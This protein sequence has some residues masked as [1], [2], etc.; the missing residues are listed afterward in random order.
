MND[1]FERRLLDLSHMADRRNM[2]VF[3]GFLSLEELNMYHSLK[4]ELSFIHSALFG[5]YEAAE[6]QMIGFLPDAFCYAPADELFPIQTMEIRVHSHGFE[7]PPGHRDYLG[8]MLGLGIDRSL[9]GDILMTG[10]GAVFFCDRKIAPF[11]C[12]NLTKAGR[13]AVSCSETDSAQSILL[14]PRMETIRGSLASVRLDS[15]ISLAFHMPRSQS[16]SLVGAGNV[17]VNGKLA[18][19]NGVH[20]K[21]DDRISVRGYGKFIYRGTLSET[22]K[23]RVVVSLDKYV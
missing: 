8:A 12:D 6:R 1:L 7:E 13:S 20:V 3:T 11:L 22:R 4:R 18:A 21:E 19:G 2:P 16:A 15:L 9:I 23:G 17:Y 5:G 14:S 10:E